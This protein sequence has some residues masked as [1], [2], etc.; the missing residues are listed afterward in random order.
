MELFPSLGIS[1]VRKKDEKRKAAFCN[2]RVVAGV[3]GVLSTGASLQEQLLLKMENARE[4]RFASALAGWG[5]LGDVLGSPGKRV[6]LWCHCNTWQIGEQFVVVSKNRH[7]R[8]LLLSPRR[9]SGEISLF[10]LLFKMRLF[11]CPVFTIFSLI[12]ITFSNIIFR[13][14]YFK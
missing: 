5:R 13:K 1:R 7:R 6:E 2:C 4:H 9:W 12:L 11:N 14:K 8:V 3:W 10:F